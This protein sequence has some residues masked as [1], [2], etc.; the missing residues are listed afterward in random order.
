[1]LPVTDLTDAGVMRLHLVVRHSVQIG[2]R[3]R[4]FALSVRTPYALEEKEGL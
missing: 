3:D 2:G 1:L 4:R